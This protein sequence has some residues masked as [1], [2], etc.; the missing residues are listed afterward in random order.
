MPADKQAEFFAR[1]YGVEK[2]FKTL[3]GFQ[4]AFLHRFL[5]CDDKFLEHV[6]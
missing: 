5:D 1:K 2:L 4:T 6:F 3:A